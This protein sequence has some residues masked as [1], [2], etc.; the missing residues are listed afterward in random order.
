MK[1]KINTTHFKSII[2]GDAIV[3]LLVTIYGFVSHYGVSF[4]VNKIFSS[5]IPWWGVWT[6]F[7][8]YLDLY[9]D[10]IILDAKSFWRIIVAII[11]T[12]PIATLLR[13][14]WLTGSFGP[15]E[16][17]FM[18]MFG[19]TATAALIAWRLVHRMKRIKLG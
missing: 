13:N 17:F 18:I 2:V 6:I 7:A 15:F 11:I 3:L 12:A 19:S 8:I 10:R 14:F 4:D 5:F 1:N 16:P 9:D